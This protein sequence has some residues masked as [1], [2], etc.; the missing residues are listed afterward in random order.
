MRTQQD[1]CYS[2]EAGAPTGRVYTTL[3]EVRGAVRAILDSDWCRET[4]PRV[5]AIAVHAAPRRGCSVGTWYEDDWTGQVELAPR[6]WNQRT[7]C[8]EVAHVLAGSLGSTSHDPEF[9][10]AYCLCVFH[11]IGL[12]A[13][14]DLRSRLLEAGCVIDPKDDA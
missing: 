9:C 5:R 3:D 2:A 13:W 8:H 4:Y 7:I 12:E 6:H 10:R 14:Q 1:A 11:V